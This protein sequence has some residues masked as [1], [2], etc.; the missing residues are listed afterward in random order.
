MKKLTEA[1]VKELI[2]NVLSNSAYYA[3]NSLGKYE[4]KRTCWNIIENN[5]EKDFM[6]ECFEETFGDIRKCKK[7]YPFLHNIPNDWYKDTFKNNTIN[8]L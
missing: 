3:Y 8:Q 7:Y 5:E 2:E 6:I 1:K 4:F